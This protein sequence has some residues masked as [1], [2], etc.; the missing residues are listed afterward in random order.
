MISEESSEI[1]G[2][3]SA[4]DAFKQYS[5][6][7]A[8]FGLGLGWF[9]YD[10]YKQSSVEE[11]P[12]VAPEPEEP[13]RFAV[14][15]QRAGEFKENAIGKSRQTRERVS[16]VIDERP[17]LVGIAGL[18]AGLMIGAVTGGYLRDNQFLGETRETIRQKARGLIH[19]TKEKAEHVLDVAR[20]AAREEAERQHLIT[21]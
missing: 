11:A 1:K 7:A 10:S 8:L 17:Y 5:G 3:G 18:A 13:E 12:R 20:R 15:K 2:A 6:P 14:I 4:M 16:R 19:D 9:L 21:H